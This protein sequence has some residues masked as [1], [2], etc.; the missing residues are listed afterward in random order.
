MKA[1]FTP[2]GKDIQRRLIDLDQ[3]NDW[4]IQQVKERTGLYMD[5]SY[6]YKIK[7]G[8]NNS[9]KVIQA[10]CDILMIAP[11]RKEPER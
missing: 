2:F 4:L 7:T 6:M 10:I 9:P 1:Q 5:S 11:P 8:R 3:T